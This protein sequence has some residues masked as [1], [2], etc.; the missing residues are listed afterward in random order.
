MHLTQKYL[1]DASIETT[2][3][4]VDEILLLLKNEDLNDAT[5]R[6]NIDKLF[7]STKV[8]DEDFNQMTVLAACLTDY[9]IAKEEAEQAQ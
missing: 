3:D 4:A 9:E 6:I 1:G 8:S 5:R 7:G 2:R